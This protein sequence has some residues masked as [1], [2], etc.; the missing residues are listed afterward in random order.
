[1]ST[2]EVLPP[3]V[4]W[5]LSALFASME[6]PKIESIWKLSHQRADAFAAQYRGKIDHSDLTADDLN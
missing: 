2:M 4:R 1:M 6:D 5:D 3:A